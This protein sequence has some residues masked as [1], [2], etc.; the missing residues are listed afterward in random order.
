MSNNIV[1]CLS[2][3]RSSCSIASSGLFSLNMSTEGAVNVSIDPEAG[4]TCECVFVS[5]FVSACIKCV[6][7]CVCVCWD[8]KL[9]ENV[10]T[11]EHTGYGVGGQVWSSG[12]L[13]WG[14]C[15]SQCR[16]SYR[17]GCS[18]LLTGNQETVNFWDSS[19]IHWKRGNPIV[20]G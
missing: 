5:E 9:R 19:G 17:V 1:L 4:C 10:Y 8:R 20:V 7:L 14:R 11:Y 3:V 12:Y 15:V 13:V 18:Q 16:G 6:C 2:K